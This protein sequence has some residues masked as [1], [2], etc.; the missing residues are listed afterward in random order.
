MF[1]CLTKIAAISYTRGEEVKKMKDYGIPVGTSFTGNIVVNDR[2]KALLSDIVKGATVG[3][4]VS[5]DTTFKTSKVTDKIM[6]VPMMHNESIT[7]V[8]PVV[9]YEKELLDC[10]EDKLSV[11]MLDNISDHEADMFIAT[12][13]SVYA[14]T[15]HEEV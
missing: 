12:K 6:C 8:P 4:R 5:R 10:S 2:S 7:D 1:G 15:L 14:L 13:S 11:S 9:M 3:I